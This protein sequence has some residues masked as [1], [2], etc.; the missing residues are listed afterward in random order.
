MVVSK[1]PLGSDG[2]GAVV[3]IER[4]V[5][6]MTS[7]GPV[8]PDVVVVWMLPVVLVW[9]LPVGV[10]WMMPET[11]VEPVGLVWMVPEEVGVWMPVGEQ[12]GLE[13]VGV[14]MPV[15]EQVAMPE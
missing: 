6:W 8:G 13:A 9:M 2:E 10:V 15:G 14:W 12:V 4:P 1:R 3:C 7:D 11:P 5:V